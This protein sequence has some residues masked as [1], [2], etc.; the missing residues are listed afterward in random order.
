MFCLYICQTS[1][2][3]ALVGQKSASDSLKLKLVMVIGCHVGDGI[4]TWVLCKSNVLLTTE[5]SLC[6][7]RA[8]SM[9][10]FPCCAHVC[11]TLA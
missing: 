11:I 2:P 1:M 5:Q 3:G 9:E 6:K 7:G 8:D 10:P 4:Q